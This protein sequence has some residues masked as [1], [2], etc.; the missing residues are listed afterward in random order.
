MDENNRRELPLGPFYRDA[1]FMHMLRITAVAFAVLMVLGFV[2]GLLF[3]SMPASLAQQFRQMVDDAGIVDESGKFSALAIFLHNLQ[4]MGWAVLYGLV[5]VLHLPALLLG[6]NSVL[7]GAMAAHYV[8]SG[9]SLLLY[10]AGLLPHGIFEIP[11]IVLSLA[12]GLYLCSY[13]T[14]RIFRRDQTPRQ[15]VFR[16]IAQVFCLAIVPLLALA[17]VLEA[18]VTPLILNSLL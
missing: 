11:A 18:Y 3:P 9:L 7:L 1:A 17:A 8:N 16:R 5:P 14:R 12:C 6:V 4:A 2:G 15:P 13:L 10:L